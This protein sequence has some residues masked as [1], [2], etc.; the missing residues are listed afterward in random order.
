M[1]VH[2]IMN[3]IPA[4]VA[5]TVSRHCNCNVEPTDPLLNFVLCVV[6]VLVVFAVFKISVHFTYNH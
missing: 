4:I 2:N 1:E 3:A 5:T 6:T